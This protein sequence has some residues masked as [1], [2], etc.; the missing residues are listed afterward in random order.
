MKKL[1]LLFITLT[2]LANISYASFPI[3]EN[4]N[5]ELLNTQFFEDDEEDD[6]NDPSLIEQILMTILVLGALGF[7][8]YYLIRAWW[9]A[10]RDRVRW[11]RILTKIV[12]I[13]GGVIALL[14]II[15]SVEGCIYNMQ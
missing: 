4:N 9:R 3:T 12:L 11:V 2:T 14:G 8:L 5:L 6:D 13:L 10:W 7:S 1:I 15:C